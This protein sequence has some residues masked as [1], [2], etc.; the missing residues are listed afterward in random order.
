DVGTRR[1]P[2]RSAY[3]AERCSRCMTRAVSRGALPGGKTAASSSN[4]VNSGGIEVGAPAIDMIRQSSS[5]YAERTRASDIRTLIFARRTNRKHGGRGME[6]GDAVLPERRRGP[7]EAAHTVPEAGRRPL[8]RG[9]DG[10]GGLLVRLVAALP[11]RPADRHR[12]GP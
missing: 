5:C 9:A 7:A 3:H 2:T 4:R 11:P 12:R 6:G 10:P 8:R 1:A